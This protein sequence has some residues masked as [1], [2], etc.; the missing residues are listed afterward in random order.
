MR[1]ATRFFEARNGS[2]R[3]D[4]NS[5]ASK[6]SASWAL[7]LALACGT[8]GADEVV[9]AS[10]AELAATV[11]VIPEPWRVRAPASDVAAPAT[12]AAPSNPL[13]QLRFRDQ[14]PLVNRLRR[15]QAVPFVTVWDS[16]DATLYVGVNRDGETGLHLRQKRDDRGVLARK[17]LLHEPD[18]LL[19]RA[20]KAGPRRTSAAPRR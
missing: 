10:A 5:S 15:L 6:P 2:V 18:P 14:Q 7:S 17:V 1:R 11:A 19:G 4:V 12:L 8:G 3:A 9:R 20:R 16:R 13:A